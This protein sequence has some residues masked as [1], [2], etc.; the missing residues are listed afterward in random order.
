VKSE[1]LLG[2]VYISTYLARRPP[3]AARATTG[4]DSVFAVGVFA[5][6]TDLTK[7]RLC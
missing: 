7:Q 1:M 2:C 6:Q 4:Q 5:S 3:L